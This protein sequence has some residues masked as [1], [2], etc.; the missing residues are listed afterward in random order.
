MNKEKTK[1]IP[2]NETD[3]LCKNRTIKEEKLY[4]SKLSK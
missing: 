2:M 1:N 4:T 3:V